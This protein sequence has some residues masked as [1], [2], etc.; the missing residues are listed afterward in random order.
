MIGGDCGLGDFD[1]GQGFTVILKCLQQRGRQAV[2]QHIFADCFQE[3][4]SIRGQRFDG[5]AA[6]GG[7]LGRA[8]LQDRVDF[9]SARSRSIAPATSPSASRLSSFRLPVRKTSLPW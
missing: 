5:F 7:F 6:L 2:P 9:Q 3:A 8:L 1:R 4:L